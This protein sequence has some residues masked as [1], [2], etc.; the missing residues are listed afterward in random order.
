MRLR[1]P[2]LSSLLAF[3]G[4][5]G[6]QPA[7]SSESLPI[8]ELL[9]RHHGEPLGKSIREISRGLARCKTIV[10]TAGVHEEGQPLNI[11][12]SLDNEGRDWIYVYTDE[13]EVAR[14][15]PEDSPFVWMNFPDIFAI[16]ARDNRFG[17]IF[18]N[19]GSRSSMYLIP[20]EVFDIVREEMGSSSTAK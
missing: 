14:V 5:V 20:R 19:S 4:V 3:T 9:R 13:T 18:V 11:A 10:P 17:G 16:A 12:A 7:P 2:L 15:M 8:S 6:C 1:I